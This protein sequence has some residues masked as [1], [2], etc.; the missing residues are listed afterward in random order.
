MMRLETELAKCSRAPVTNPKEIRDLIIELFQQ[1]FP[2]CTDEDLL[3]RP[4]DAIKFCAS[5][6][7]RLGVVL[8][9]EII[10]RTLTNSRKRR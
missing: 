7:D 2:I 10:L 4:V 6:R 8:C 9:D 1:Y 5:V 3:F